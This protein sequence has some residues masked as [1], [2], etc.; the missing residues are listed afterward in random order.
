[1]QAGPVLSGMKAESARVEWLK[2]RDSAVAHVVRSIADHDFCPDG[3]NL[4]LA[5]ADLGRAI[6]AK[7]IPETWLNVHKQLANRLLEPFMWHT[8]LVTAT[9]WTNFWNL[10]AHEDAQ[11]EIRHLAEL[12]RSVWYQSE[13]EQLAHGEWHMPLMGDRGGHPH[14]IQLPNETRLKVAV[15]RCARVSY[16]THSGLR[17]P[18]ADVALHDRLLESGH[19][20]PFEHIARPLTAAELT[21][22]RWC[23]NFRGWSAYR[24]DVPGEADP[25]G[26]TLVDAVGAAIAH[27]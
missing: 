8:L 13:P 18:L 12:M 4:E 21:R 27:V 24:K 16:L 23:G 26:D 7:N 17:D 9:E 2:A 25:L 5:V 22:N 20:S 6:A 19:L 11:P 15:G 10:R 14:D 1:M 3:S